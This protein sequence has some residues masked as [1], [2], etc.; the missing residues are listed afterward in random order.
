MST[1]RTMIG[2]PFSILSDLPIYGPGRTQQIVSV[3]E[4]FGAFNLQQ[5]LVYNIP[6]A[7]VSS[8]PY[9]PVI[10]PVPVITT[11][12]TAALYP[13]GT[14][15][16]INP[17]VVSPF[18]SIAIQQNGRYLIQA[19]LL[20]TDTG[21]HG[22][23]PVPCVLVDASNTLDIQQPI[24]LGSG[25]LLSVSL[26]GIIVITDSTIHPIGIIITSPGSTNLNITGLNTITICPF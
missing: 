7:V 18:T 8:N 4:N 22:P 15:L 1:P 24:T 17:S 9:Y 26:S 5:K 23:E 16:Q 25:S 20:M 13:N 11:N 19:K 10:N 21:S 12:G 14:N 2:T 3:T 6:P